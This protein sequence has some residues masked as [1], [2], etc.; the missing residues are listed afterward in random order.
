MKLRKNHFFVDTSC[1]WEEA[2]PGI[3]RKIIGYDDQLMLVKVIFEKN[4]KAPT[5]SHPHSQSSY[6]ESGRFEVTLGNEKRI[7]SAGDGFIVPSNLTH[8]VI[9]LEPGIIVDAFSPKRDDF[10]S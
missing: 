6:I 1:D 5:H 10:L 2:F 8:S 3:Q 7:L 4:I 9:S